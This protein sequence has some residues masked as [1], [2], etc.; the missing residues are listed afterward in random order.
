MK[1]LSICQPF[2]ELIVQNKKII[3]LRKWNT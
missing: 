3:E 2:A 1:C